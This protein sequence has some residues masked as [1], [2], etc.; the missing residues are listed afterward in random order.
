MIRNKYSYRH[1]QL[2]RSSILISFVAFFL[3]FQI[4]LNGFG[5]RERI[6]KLEP[7]T[8]T[9]IKSLHEGRNNSETQKLLE[10]T[11]SREKFLIEEVK[12]PSVKRPSVEKPPVERPPLERPPLEPPKKQTSN[13][14]KMIRESV[15]K[16][17]TTTN[18]E[19]KEPV[20]KH[21]TNP[22]DDLFNN[23]SNLPTEQYKVNKEIDPF[24]DKLNKLLDENQ[25]IDKRIISETEKISLENCVVIN[26]FELG[27]SK[28]LTVYKQSSKIYEGM[29]SNKEDIVEKMN[30]IIG[31][32]EDVIVL[33]EINRT[34]ID[35]RSFPDKNFYYCPITDLAR[36]LNNIKK[37]KEID[38]NIES[39]KIVNLLPINNQQAK[40]MG[41]EKNA[42]NTFINAHR[43]LKKN[44]LNRFNESQI[45]TSKY[46]NN[47]RSFF[48]FFKTNSTIKVKEKLLLDLSNSSNQ[49]GQVVLV[50]AAHATKNGSEIIIS[51]KVRI[52]PEDIYIL[53]NDCFK[54]SIIILEC[55]DCGLSPFT[56]AFREKGAI[57]VQSFDEKVP[58]QSIEQTAI[59]TLNCFYNPDKS[60]KSIK[61][62]DLINIIK[63][64][65]NGSRPFNRVNIEIHKKDRFS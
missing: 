15:E 49:K 9:K 29:F 64:A 14:G 3:C 48:S 50:F 28:G 36:G 54:N 12:T 51:E 27:D 18:T 46:N 44:V 22:T 39:I 63:K 38:L 19:P 5:Q 20:E 16:S 4:S 25:K 2:L 58:I 45:L 35:E 65:S 34:Q 32:T 40:D 31:N 33:D 59:I 56:D 42:G 52:T 61:A 43:S 1:N 11:F 7:K 47:K 8:D 37:M 53:P 13:F 10:K 55:C 6:A 23:K 62:L 26:M 60:L 57:A 41:I 21:G 30:T 17:K 24:D